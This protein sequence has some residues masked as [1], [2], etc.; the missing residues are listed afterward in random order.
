MMRISLAAAVVV[1]AL[2]GCT[3]GRQQ[4]NQADLERRVAGVVPGQTTVAELEQ[5]A[6]G[7]PT[8]IT[9]IGQKQLYA[10]TYGDSKSEALTL[11]IINIGKTN[12]G[13]D[14]ALFLID[15]NGVVESA[16]VGTNSKDLPWQWWAFGD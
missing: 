1:I 4:I 5:M 7:P 14:T 9:P 15:E 16:R 11:L 8:S 6:G 12:T 10:Y 2:G 3:W 13:L